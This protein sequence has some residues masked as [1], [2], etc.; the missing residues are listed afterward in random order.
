MHLHNVYFTLNNAS[1]EATQK[2]VDECTTY[3]TVQNGIVSFSCGVRETNANREVNDTDFDVS[4]HILFETRDAHDAYQTDA[5]HQ[6]F[7]DRNND[8]WSK[9]RVFD[10]I[11][12][13][14]K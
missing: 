9:V 10:T 12:K 8:N 4:L 7:I 2:L 11:I 5:Q 1:P 14:Q 6:I 13:S 3:L